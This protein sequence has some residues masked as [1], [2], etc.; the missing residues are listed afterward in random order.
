MRSVRNG[1]P[2]RQAEFDGGPFAGAAADFTSAAQILQAL[3]HS[4]KA[5]PSGANAVNG[6]TVSVVRD[7]NRELFAGDFNFQAHFGRS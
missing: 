3:S 5:L 2:Q 7:R 6:E 1:F 4:G